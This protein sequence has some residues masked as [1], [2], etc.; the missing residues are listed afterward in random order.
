[1]EDVRMLCNALPHEKGI[2]LRWMEHDE[3]TGA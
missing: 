2:S 1:M 3:T